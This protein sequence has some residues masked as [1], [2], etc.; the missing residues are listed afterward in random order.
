MDYYKFKDPEIQA[1]SG[2]KK[3]LEE[4]GIEARVATKRSKSKAPEV[5]ITVRLDAFEP[6]QPAVKNVELQVFLWVNGTIESAA[7]KKAN[8]LAL[9]LEGAFPLLPR[10]TQNVKHAEVSSWSPVEDEG[11]LQVRSLICSFLMVADKQVI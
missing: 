2:L 11:I 5:E 7:Y 4:L 8:D 3:L 10:F 6:V 1:V 9:T